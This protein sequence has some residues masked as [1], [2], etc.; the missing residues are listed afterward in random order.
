[1]ILA[2]DREGIPMRALFV[3]TSSSS[4][5]PPHVQLAHSALQVNIQLKYY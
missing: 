4:S 3:D 1:M 2:G 5:P